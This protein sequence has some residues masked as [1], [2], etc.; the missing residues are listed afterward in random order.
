VPPFRHP[1]DAPAGTSDLPQIILVFSSAATAE[2]RVAGIPAA[3][4]A[5]HAIAAIAEQDGIRRCSIV[6]DEPWLPSNALLAECRRLAPHLRLGFAIKPSNDD[7]LT[8]RG[9]TFVAALAQRHSGLWRENVLPALFDACVKGRVSMSSALLPQ[10]AALK[11]LRRAS[12]DVL[13]A[14]GKGGD[15]IVSRYINRP[16]SR[17]ISHQLLRIPAVTPF[18]ASVGTALLGL[19]MAFALFLGDGTGLI[20]GAL[21]FQAASIFDGVDG[22]I[23]RATNR[24][25]ELGATLD[26]VID[27]FTNLAF[28]TG[29]TVN[30]A[31]AGDV[32][33]AVAGSIALVTLGAGL[34]LIGRHASAMGEPMNF[35]VIKRQL[36]NGRRTSRLTEFFIHLTMRDFFAAACALMIVAGFTDILLI[37]FAVIALGWF[38]VTALVLSRLKR[39]T[40]GGMT[41]VAAA[42]RAEPC[43]LAPA[44]LA[45][46]QSGT[47]IRRD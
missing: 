46:S 18:H 8:V 5:A 19:A 2:Y 14:T 12:R 35:D 31:M 13:A 25:S 17:A 38:S 42:R 28:I 29:V 37:A 24:T 3:A 33:G 22:E 45:F 7:M 1:I 40:R 4:R 23:A 30:V 6:V 11:L 47:A 15:G 44:S 9:E 39:T 10:A 21:L 36:R 34:L 20:L 16:I 27:A 43:A 41:M 26:S 32:A